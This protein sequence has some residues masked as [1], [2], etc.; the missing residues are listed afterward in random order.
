MTDIRY[1]KEQLLSLFSLANNSPSWA[2]DFPEV[3]NPQP[4]SPFFLTNPDFDASAVTKSEQDRISKANAKSRRGRGGSA[5]F[6][7]GRY[8]TEKTSAQLFEGLRQHQ[9]SPRTK[10]SLPD[11]QSTD[12]NLT[13]WDITDDVPDDLLWSDDSNVVATAK[14][15]GNPRLDGLISSCPVYQED[16][17]SDDD[18]ITFPATSLLSSAP[19]E[20]LSRSLDLFSSSKQET[21][22]AD[23]ITITSKGSQPKPSVPKP[24]L[25]KPSSLPPPKPKT[26]LLF[27]DSFTSAPAP[28]T[29]TT[30][31]NWEYLD[32]QAVLQGP[33][34]SPVMQR[35]YQGGYLPDDLQ[36]RITNFD[37]STHD[38][39]YVQLKDW[40]EVHG[41]F[42]IS[43]TP[44]S[45]L[46]SNFKI[47]K[48]PVAAQK[49]LKKKPIP[50]SFDPPLEYDTSST[51][52]FSQEVDLSSLLPETTKEKE[53]RKQ[54]PLKKKEKPSL[55]LA[56]IQKQQFEAMQ[57]QAQAQKAAP[58]VKS[59]T[60]SVAPSWSAMIGQSRKAPSKSLKEIQEEERLSRQGQ[61]MKASK[62]A[63]PSNLTLAERIA[64]LHGSKMT[65]PAQV[66]T[67]PVQKSSAPSIPIKPVATKASTVTKVQETR[68]SVAATNSKNSNIKNVTNIWDYK[69]TK[70]AQSLDSPTS[71][72]DPSET[73]KP[74]V[75]KS[76]L[77]WTEQELVKFNYPTEGVSNF[78]EFLLSL[79]TQQQVLDYCRQFL[80]V[81]SDVDSFATQFWTRWTFETES[82][83]VKKGK[84][85]KTKFRPIN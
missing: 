65:S 32:P 46:V 67:S 59:A 21:S 36:V 11:D 78:I 50:V 19:A 48:K 23:F 31:S 39:G 27:D 15:T 55:T 66:A 73:S 45:E 4:V 12:K 52:A 79:K 76:L 33:Y 41:S 16:S 20:P 8:R 75:S 29:V 51:T 58:Q 81:S 17:S 72:S 64:L 71:D 13:K 35:W 34:P 28:S 44:D 77:S 9:D 43:V 69:P 3:I 10:W 26:T 24:S 22:D 7:G 82:K 47:P 54:K 74:V 25:P 57:K 60:S 83:S 40:L 2:V 53:E 49:P 38:K 56:E 85:T 30:L 37:D 6:K 70:N 68:V 61:P 14:D 62:P 5:S 80:S 42:M 18:L 1:T 63:L 84:K